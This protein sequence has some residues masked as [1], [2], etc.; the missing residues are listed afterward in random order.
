[1]KE[2]GGFF[3]LEVNNSKEYHSDAL[4]LN[5][6][7]NCL[8][9]ILR[10]RNISKIYIPYFVCDV[11]LE[12]ITKMNI[13]YEFYRINSSFEPLFEKTL[14]SNEVFLYVN[15][16]GLKQNV[17]ELLSCKYGNKLVIDNTQAFFSKPINNIDTFYS[18]RKFVGVADGGY[19]YTNK[20][21]DIKFDK[22]VSFN[23]M[24]HLIKRLDCGADISYSDFKDNTQNLVCNEILE[25]SN[26]T[27]SILSGIDYEKIRKI[28]EDN[29]LYLHNELSKYNELDISVENINGPMV[30]PFMIRKNKLREILIENKIFVAMYWPNVIDWCDINYLEY[31]MTKYILPLP[32]DQRYSIKEMKKILSILL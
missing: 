32:I 31:S 3:E 7:R 12:P 4:S 9:Y 16:F 28:R 20:R 11:V 1:M 15:Y 17:V 30:Y 29:F 2:I 14:S 22:D 5:T 8:E 23:R 6:G 19:L 21:L 27:H 18:P 25:M 13:E 26:I 10:A 24:S